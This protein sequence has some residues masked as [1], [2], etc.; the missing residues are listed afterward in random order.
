MFAFE[1]PSWIRDAFAPKKNKKQSTCRPSLEAL[2]ARYAPAVY[3]VT[4]L[5][6]GAA[7]PSGGAGTALSPFTGATLRGAINDI[8][9][10]FASAPNTVILSAGATYSLATGELNVSLATGGLLLVVP[11]GP[12]RAIIQKVSV[13]DFRILE[14]S[15]NSNVV[16]NS[17]VVRG[18]FVTAQGDASGGGILNHG[19]LTLANA[20]V[21]GNTAQATGTATGGGVANSGSLVIVNSMISSNTAEGVSGQFAT[22]SGTA[23]GG[24]IGL[25]SEEGNPKPSLSLSNSTVI[26]NTA[27]SSKFSGS[28]FGGGIFDEGGSTIA[29][30]VSTISGNSALG[31]PGGVISDF[32]NFDGGQARGGGLSSGFNNSGSAVTITR[33]TFS[34][35]TARGGDTSTDGTSGGS[36][37]GGGLDLQRYALL[38]MVNSTISGNL[39]QGGQRAP[40]SE[41]SNDGTGQGGGIFQFTPRVANFIPGYLI[42]LT[43]TQNKAFSGDAVSDSGTGGGIFNDLEGGT[44]LRLWNTIVAQNFVNSLQ[45]ETLISSD[46]FGKFQSDPI[47]LSGHNLIGNTDGSNGFKLASGDIFG[48]ATTGIVN[49]GLNPLAFNGGPTQTHLPQT[50]SKAVNAGD[51]AVLFFLGLTTDQRGPG[52]PRKVGLHID[53]GSVELPASVNRRWDR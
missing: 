20:I 23:R 48:T 2:E 26:A 29:I 3:R 19:R 50:T 35:N 41:E 6:D 8:N 4:T 21:S 40:D 12:S 51:D 45:D 43:I 11:A 52:F 27:R 53:I 24:G 18:G 10:R 17:T 49:A 47:R 34:G 39:A 5:S 44:P 30:G 32:A 38:L 14:I 1:L 33:S 25:F 7:G 31:G 9:T 28:A 22:G 15:R 46:V 37:F 13:S 36:A 16:L 42:N